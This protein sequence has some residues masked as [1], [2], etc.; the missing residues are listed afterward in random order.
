MHPKQIQTPLILWFLFMLP[1]KTPAQEFNFGVVGGAALSDDFRSETS[2]ATS[3]PGSLTVYTTTHS[4]SKDY[5][6]G[7][8]FELGL[9]ARFSV[10]LDGLYRP[11]NFTTSTSSVLGGVSPSNTVVTWEFPVLLKYRF[12]IPKASPFLE[13]GPSFRTAGNLNDTSPSN[14]GVAAGAGIGTSFRKIGISAEGRYT[15]WSADQVSHPYEP[16]TNPDQVEFLTG[17]SFHRGN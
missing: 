13:L 2:V 3:L 17:W 7:G 1:I 5:V 4:N 14:H 15:R 11:M 16:R 12:Q 9:P 6:V 8:M 10:E